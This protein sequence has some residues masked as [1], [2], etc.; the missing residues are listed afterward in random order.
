L[1][2]GLFAACGSSTNPSASGVFPA[3]GFA[4]RTVRVEIS[5]D[6]TSWA[7]GAVVNFGGGITVSNVMVASPTDLFCDVAIDPTAPPGLSDVS[8]SSGGTFTLTKAFNVT[9]PVELTFQGGVEQGGSPAFTLVNHDFD[10]PFDLSVDATGALANLKLTGPTG[11]DFEVNAQGS[12]AYSL[13]GSAFLDG[14]AMP[15]ALTIASGP[16]A[17]QITSVIATVDIKA[18]AAT[19]LTSGTAAMGTITNPGDTLWYSLAAQSGL[20]HMTVSFSDQNASP[21]VGILENGS[22]STFLGGTFAIVPSAETV[23]IVVLDTAGNAGYSVTIDAVSDPLTAAAEPAGATDDLIGG[24][25]LATIPYEMTGATLSVMGDIDY[26]KVVIGAG[27]T[28]KKLHITTSAGTDDLTDTQVDV[29]NS[30]NTA[31]VLP[32]GAVDGGTP[33]GDGGFEC[34]LGGICG[35]DVVVAPLA[36]GTYY[37]K[38]SAGSAYTTSDKAYVLLAWFE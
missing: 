3:E 38:V 15:G 25:P 24:A 11:T 19:P 32:G 29:V 17:T 36:A 5:G 30:T 10:N 26:I 12:T 37:I 34:E 13:S 4:G 31:S 33:G 21:A 27:D 18:R 1:A 2:F 16:T 14:D 7:D 20:V 8:V 28:T 9:S 6:A 22:Y 35:E 23:N